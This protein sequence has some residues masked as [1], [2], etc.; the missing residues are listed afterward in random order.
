MLCHLPEQQKKEFAHLQQDSNGDTHHHNK[1][2]KLLYPF[3][4][5]SNERV[6]RSN[7]ASF[8]KKYLVIA[9]TLLSDR[10]GMF[11][12]AWLQQIWRI[13]LV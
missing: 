10:Y 2:H 11:T 5:Q 4:P 7:S 3:S 9:L 8:T 1:R 13:L 12:L 6:V